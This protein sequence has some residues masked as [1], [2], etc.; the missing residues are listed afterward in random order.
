MTLPDEKSELGRLLV[1]IITPTYNQAAFLPETIESILTQDHAPLEYIVIDDGSTDATAQIL[2]SYDDRLIR[3]RQDNKGQSATINRGFGVAKGDILA[4]LNSDDTLLPGA[5]RRVAGY[6]AAHPEVDIVFGDTLFTDA[7]G[8]TLRCSDRRAAFDY[9]AFVVSAENPI[10]QPS[11]FLRRRVIE[12]EGL[13]DPSLVYFM[14]WD[15][16]L[17]AG[18]AHAIAYTPDLLSTYR[19]HPASNTESRAAQVAPELEAVYRGYFRR[20]D[21]PA[22]IRAQ[23]RRAMANMYLTRGGY[24]IK[25]G[26]RMG[27]AWAAL[28][29]VAIHPTSFLRV[30]TLRKALYCLLGGSPLPRPAQRG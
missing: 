30:G 11:A 22:R 10:P 7:R 29:A 9:E 8:Q 24:S 12:K 19:L 13:L 26:H 4:W 18:L 16:W 20:L 1:S 17:R 21:V 6:F 14:D 27:A 23:E 15:Y 25:G 5:V 28:H 3:I 2:S